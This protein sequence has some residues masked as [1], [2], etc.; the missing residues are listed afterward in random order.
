MSDNFT[1]IFKNIDEIRESVNLGVSLEDEINFH[2]L[3]I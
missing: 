3:S 1:Y 2:H